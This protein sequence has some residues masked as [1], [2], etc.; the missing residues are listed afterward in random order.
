MTEPAPPPALDHRSFQRAVAER[1]AADGAAPGWPAAELEHIE[2]SLRRRTQ[3]SAATNLAAHLRALDQATDFDIDAPTASSR[4]VGRGVKVAISRATG[5]YVG[6]IAA[7]MRHFAV[8][9]T[10]AV[11]ASAARVDELEQR[12][13]ALEEAVHSDAAA[14]PDGPDA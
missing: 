1:L 3:R 8:A 4:A 2:R 12:V 5:W 6:H 11:R 9:T 13:A 7:Q 10:R 14:H